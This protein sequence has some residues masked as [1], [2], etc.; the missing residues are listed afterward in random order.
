MAFRKKRSADISTSIPVGVPSY[1]VINSM[2]K[3]LINTSQY[4]YHES[5]AFEVEEV[6]LNEPGLRGS[7]RGTFINNPNQ[8]ILGGVV[9]PLMPNILSVPVIGEHVVVVEYNGQH[10]YTSIINRKGSPNENSI[11]GT[12][13]PFEKNTTYGK[14]FERKQVKQIEIGEG[15]ILYQG[16]FGQSIHFDGHNNVP[17]IK[18]RTNID[19]SDGNLTTESIDTDDSSIYL[20]SDGLR[21][22]KFDDQQ[23]QGKKVLIKSDGIFIKGSDIR[24]GTVVE[25]D[26]QPVVKGDDLLELF[27]DLISALENA[28]FIGVAPGSPTTPAV[29]VAQ[30][31]NLR[32]KLKNILSTKVKTQ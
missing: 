3:Q 30:F 26:L 15:C 10:Y 28:T 4:D 11:P 6:I 31:T 9:K 8:E 2:V 20:L 5:E 29:N 1:S 18:I 25:N 17:S 7:V 22:Q 12:A 16:R 23:I 21:G 14:T 32:T 27:E 13:K 19:E 24:L